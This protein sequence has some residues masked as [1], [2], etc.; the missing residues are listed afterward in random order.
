[1]MATSL[2]TDRLIARAWSPD[3]DALAA[4]EIYSDPA[5]VR[6]LSSIR[7]PVSSVDEARE[8]LTDWCMRSDDPAYGFWAVQPVDGGDP[9]GTAFV[10]PLPPL[11]S[12]VEIG[13]HLHPAH[14]GKGYATEIGQATIDYAFRKGVAEVYAVIKP[15]NDRSAAVARRLGM[16]YVGRTDKYYGQ[17]MDVYRIRPGDL[18]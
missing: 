17:E 7:E 11:N 10:R 6:Y 1:M 16:E 18:L 3:K 13:W 2:R 8:Y 9:I 12:D 5:V 14:W 15:G 4:Y